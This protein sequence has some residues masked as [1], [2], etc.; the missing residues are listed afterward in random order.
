MFQA[1]IFDLDGVITDTAAF[2]F[3]AWQALAEKLG[4]SQHRAQEKEKQ[5]TNSQSHRQATELHP[6]RF[7]VHRRISGARLYARNEASRPVGDFA[8]IV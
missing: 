7:R 3:K 8:E 2:H 4:L 5:Q 6:A 1:V